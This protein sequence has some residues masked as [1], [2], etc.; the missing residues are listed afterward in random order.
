MNFTCEYKC[1]I[2]TYIG[3]DNQNTKKCDD[4]KTLENWIE[5]MHRWE[6]EIEMCINEKSAVFIWN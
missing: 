3:S 2:H 5:N 6:S 1:E 4:E